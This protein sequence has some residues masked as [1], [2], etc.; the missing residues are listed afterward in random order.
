MIH[1]Q[2]FTV[3]KKLQNVKWTIQENHSAHVEH[4]ASCPIISRVL[5]VEKMERYTG[6]DA[7]WNIPDV[8]HLIW[9]P[10]KNT[11]D[12]F[13]KVSINQKVRLASIF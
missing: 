8:I 13:N 9:F 6:I 10:F 1:A 2:D 4:I 11:V 3:R 12:V 5:C 7:I